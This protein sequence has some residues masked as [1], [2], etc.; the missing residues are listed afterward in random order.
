MNSLGKY[1][2]LWVGCCSSV[3]LLGELGLLTQQHAERLL[4]LIPVLNGLASHT[5]I[6][7][8]LG[9]S[10][11]DLSDKTWVN[12]LGNEVVATEGEVVDLIDIV[13]NIGNRLLGQIGNGVNSSELHLLVDGTGVNVEGT[14]EDVGE[15]DNVVNLVGI[16]GTTC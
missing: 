16:V 5:A 12:G 15:T 2:A 6:H 14:T 13:D 11:A 9:N 1:Y 3:E 8:C 10:G 4:I 7:C